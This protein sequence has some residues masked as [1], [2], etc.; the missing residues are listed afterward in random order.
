[1]TCY[2]E[3][4]N[5]STMSAGQNILL[6]LSIVLGMAAAVVT[7][8]Y[9]TPMPDQNFKSCDRP[10]HQLD[11]PMICRVKLNIEMYHIDNRI[12]QD[13]RNNSSTSSHCN[14]IFCAMTDTSNSN[15]IITANRQLP[16][17]AIQVC[18][19]DILIVDV[20]NKIPG[21]SVSLHWRGQPNAETPFMD[22]VPMITQ[23][24]VP[25][26]TTFQYKF[27]ASYAG[28]HFYHAFSDN[29]RSR[30]LFGALVVRKADKIEPHKKL[31]DF[32][33][34]DHIVLIS[35]WSGDFTY[36][37][38]AKKD[39]PKALLING[40]APSE[41]G[42]SLTVYH[43]KPGKRY[44]F[45]AAH[46]GGSVGCPVSLSID[47]H[48]LKIIELD[49]NAINPYEVSSVQLAKGE[50][51]DFVL[52][53]SAENGAF[54]LNVKSNCGNE[55][56]GLAVINY[57]A[58][59]KSTKNSVSRNEIARSFNTSFCDTQIGKVCLQDVKAL[60]KIDE[61]LRNRE[62]DHT[63][64]LEIDY[65]YR[66][67]ETSYGGFTDLRSKVYRVNN[68][69]F[70]FPS[71]PLLTQFSDVPFDVICSQFVS[72]QRCRDRNVC[73]CV[74]VQFVKL[75]S[76]VEVVLIDQ[77]GDEEHVFHF[78][79]VHFYVVGSRQFDRPVSRQ[80]VEDL[81][82]TNHLLK[83]NLLN[84]VRKDTV[85][86]PKY[87]VVVIRFLAK[88][89]GMWMLRDEKSVGWTKGLDTVFQFGDIGEM[90]A[91]PSNFPSCG[92]YIGP[93]FFLL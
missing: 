82:K 10:C 78:H 68:Y 16:G 46:T 89:P 47:K 79:G 53:A 65:K 39:V 93:D 9:L 1:M 32:D 54:F 30:G 22:G 69:T 66:E 7:I 92:N 5:N 91:T 60:I 15:G 31:Y 33:S 48:M 64:I 70:S 77:S 37:G 63:A 21:H 41:Q 42:S 11:W 85:R 13:C 49:G 90:V 71:S 34:K 52:K 86:V 61:E 36:D 88:N 38:M 83:R 28:T 24:P 73:E 14:N 75:G 67:K 80:E 6:R 59:K 19:N 40:R 45:R 18:E 51:I 57:E 62:V 74:H 76:S 26:F 84:P 20:I 3:K 23:C 8:L 55:L 2:P 87:G 27:R 4:N 29:D 81:D 56:S 25:S 50:R 43:V 58:V 72:P 17:P 44:R 12:C 35:E